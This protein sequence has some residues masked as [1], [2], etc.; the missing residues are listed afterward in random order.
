MNIVYFFLEGN[1]RVI[2]I[3]FDLLFK[4]ELKKIVFWERIDKV[5]YLSVMERSFVNDLEIKMFL[6]KYLSFNINDF[7]I[8]IKGI[9]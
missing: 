1:G 6:K 4:K 5:V 8:F 7:L 3:W 2:R 9:M